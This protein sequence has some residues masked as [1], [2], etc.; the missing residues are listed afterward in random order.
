LGCR[1]VNILPAIRKKKLLTAE[2]AEIA[3]KN[4]DC[5]WLPNHW[6][7]SK[8]QTPRVL[9]NIHKDLLGDLG[10]LGG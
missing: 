6:P 2:N 3:E 1:H 8:V 7:K 5:H 4:G 10:V 9:L